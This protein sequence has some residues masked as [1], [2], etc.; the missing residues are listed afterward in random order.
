MQ[1]MPVQALWTVHLLPGLAAVR[2][3]GGQEAELYREEMSTRA[4]EQATGT[5]CPFG[6]PVTRSTWW[7]LITRQLLELR[8]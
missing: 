3:P 8:T 2:R 7:N 1:R 5:V 4:G 6:I